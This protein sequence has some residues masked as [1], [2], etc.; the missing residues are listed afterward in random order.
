MS[1]YK[2]KRISTAL[3]AVILCFTVINVITLCG[4]GKKFAYPFMQDVSEIVSVRITVRKS[5]DN[6]YQNAYNN[7]KCD[8]ELIKEIEEIDTFLEEFEEIK[9]GKYI[10]GKPPKIVYD[11]YAILVIYSND[12][13]EYI[14]D[15]AQEIY[16]DERSLNGKIHCDENE[17]NKFIEKWLANNA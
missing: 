7:D 5:Y 14:S 16:N 2:H 11:T 17:F 4:C 9:F 1:T 8:Y 6:A 3:L 13:C 15:Y 10:I 12:D